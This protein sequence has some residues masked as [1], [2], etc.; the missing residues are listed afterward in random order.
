MSLE[1]FENTLL[2]IKGDIMETLEEMRKSI[3]NIDNAIVA[4]LSER[5]KVTERVGHYK[6]QNGLPA[7]DVERESTQFTR[8]NKLAQHYGLDPEFAESYLVTVI[9]R[10]VR[11][12]QEIALI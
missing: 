12:H 5:F 1:Q 7:K 6:A 10:V 3:D 4:M 11:N 9:E 2:C 8:M